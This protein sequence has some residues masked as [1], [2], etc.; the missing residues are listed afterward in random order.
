LLQFS[1]QRFLFPF[2]IFILL[3]FI[4]Y[5]PVSRVTLALFLVGKESI[6][7]KLFTASRQL[8]LAKKGPKEGVF[9]PLLHP[10]LLLFFHS[11]FSPPSLNLHSQIAPSSN[12][13]FISRRMDF[14][15]IEQ[16]YVQKAYEDLKCRSN[17]LAA[18]IDENHDKKQK[19]PCVINFLKTIPSNSLI[20]DIGWLII[21]K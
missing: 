21:I 7:P 13:S 20:L 2:S 4:F 12:N 15:F 5:F 16:N 1:S 17:S 18:E 3:F 14:A 6:G 8:A 11:I 9:L 19:L 10:R